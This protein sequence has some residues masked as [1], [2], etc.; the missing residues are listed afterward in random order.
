MADFKQYFVSRIV[1]MLFAA[2]LPY[3]VR[4]ISKYFM[5]YL[6]LA[7]NS[8]E[9]YQILLICLLVGITVLAISMRG[10]ALAQQHVQ[11]I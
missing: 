1:L 3:A 2:V 5:D 7:I 9:S 4:Q 10:I 6:I 11:M 8:E